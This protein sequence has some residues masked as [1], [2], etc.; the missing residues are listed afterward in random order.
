MKLSYRRPEITKYGTM[1]EFT[2]ASSGSGG[3]AGGL[4]NGGVSIRANSN[5]GDPG[6]SNAEVSENNPNGNSL[7]D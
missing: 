2:N 6:S 4:G 7:I 3:D 1:K 5:V